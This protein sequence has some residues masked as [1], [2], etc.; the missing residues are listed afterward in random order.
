MGLL[1]CVQKLQDYWL[2]TCPENFRLL[3]KLAVYLIF[4]E[5]PMKPIH[6]VEGH[7][8]QCFLEERHTE[9]VAAN[10]QKHA[11][12]GKSGRIDNLHTNVHM[13]ITL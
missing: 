4:C 10:I 3:F 7:Q 5:M 11:P 6:L 9:V 2:Q 13:S 8:V 12:P 1:R